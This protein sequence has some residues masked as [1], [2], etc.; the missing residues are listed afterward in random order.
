MDGGLNLNEITWGRNPILEALKAGRTLNKILLATGAHGSTEEILAR[1]RE[2]GVPVKVV[3]RHLL[4]EMTEGAKHQGVVAYCSPRE[5]VEVEDILK[6][7]S[8]RHETPLVVVLAGWEDPQNFGAILRT[9]E[10]AGAHG[11]IIPERR[12][13]PLTGVVAKASAGAVEYLPV[14]RVGNLSRTLSDLKKAGLW[15]VGADTSGQT[16]YFQA[17]LTIPLALVIGGEGKGLGHLAKTCDYLVR[18]P[19]RGRIGSLNV[20]AAG[21]ILIYEVLRQR[22]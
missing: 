7:A 6:S 5:Y 10:S 15:I 22:A 21:S 4:D 3:E 18:I 14:S 1:A 20:S 8:D 9:A 19:M 2:R 13:V 12:A 16:D 11:I 17:D